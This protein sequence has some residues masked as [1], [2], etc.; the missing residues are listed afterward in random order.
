MQVL[1]SFDAHHVT[2][3]FIVYVSTSSFSKVSQLD[4]R[5]VTPNKGK[6][7][8]YPICLCLNYAWTVNPAFSVHEYDDI[9]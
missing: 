9:F 1:H 7:E 5:K 8:V 6:V 3:Q 4:L 2:Q